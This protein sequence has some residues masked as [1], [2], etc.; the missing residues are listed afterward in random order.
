VVAVASMLFYLKKYAEN[1]AEALVFV[2]G[3]V[4]CFLIMGL[5]AS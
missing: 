5:M 2:A 3:I 4:V 1:I